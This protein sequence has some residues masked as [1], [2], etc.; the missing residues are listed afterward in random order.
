MVGRLQDQLY[1][2]YNNIGEVGA[3]RRYDPRQRLLDSSQP[4]SLDNNK[5]SATRAQRRSQPA[6]LGL[7]NNNIGDEGATALAAGVAVPA[8]PWQHCGCSHTSIR[9]HTFT[10]GVGL[11]QTHTPP[12]HN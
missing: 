7:N 4:G 8:A 3:D 10:F 1:L 2:A 6:T 12:F 9:G 5:R 11:K